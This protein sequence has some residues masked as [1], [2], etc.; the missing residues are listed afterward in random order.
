MRILTLFCVCLNCFWRE[1]NTLPS[2]L[3]NPRQLQ[4]I[5]GKELARILALL[6]YGSLNM[7]FYLKNVAQGCVQTQSKCSCLKQIAALH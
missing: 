3:R 7:V 2:H 5:S 6:T 1:R 4:G